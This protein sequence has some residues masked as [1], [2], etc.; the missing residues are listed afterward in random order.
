MVEA[1]GTGKQEALVGTGEEDELATGQVLVER[2]F[3]GWEQQF[4]K[5]SE[6]LAGCVNE[7]VGQLE[8]FGKVRKK[9]KA[10]RA[11]KAMIGRLA[12]L[13]AFCLASGSAV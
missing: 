5:A 4:R 11:T 7:H 13:M 6:L 9:S 2:I 8:I 12:L 10:S 1:N 3:D